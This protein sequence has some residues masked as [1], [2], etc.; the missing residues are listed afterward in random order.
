MNVL[1]PACALASITTF[2]MLVAHSSGALIATSL[3]FGVF[4]GAYVSLPPTI[5]VRLTSNPALIG[6]RV[7]MGFTIGGLGVLAGG[8]GA[9]GIAGV[10]PNYNWTGMWVFGAAGMMASGV[11]FTIVRI[12]KSNRNWKAVV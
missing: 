10:P 12:M 7:G 9:G 4:S 11:L 3:I 1:I 5:L 6:T 2:C 8:P